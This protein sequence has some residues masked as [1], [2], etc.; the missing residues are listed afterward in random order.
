MKY[1]GSVA[2]PVGLGVPEAASPGSVEI[3]FEAGWV[4]SLSAEKRTVG[5]AGI[6]TEDLNRTSVFGRPWVTVGLPAKL[7]LTLGVVPPIELSGLEPSFAFLALGRPLHEAERWRLGGRLFG[8]YGVIEGDLTC[9]AGDVAA[10]ADPSRNPFLCEEPS[11]DE[12]TIRTLG[13]ELSLAWQPA[14]LPR[15]EPHVALAVSRLDMDLQ[16]RARYSGIVD[17]SRLST[18][19]TTLALTAGATYRTGDRSRLNVD[20]FYSPLDVVR[21]PSTGAVNDGLFNIRVSFGFRLR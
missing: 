11:R 5:F 16:V 10:G 17:T 1:F 14:G 13:G 4:P 15:I 18:D 9:S 6:K 2:L 8:Q 20:L 7:S 12:M 21:P 19:G 3:G